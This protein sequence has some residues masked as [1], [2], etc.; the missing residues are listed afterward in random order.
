MIDYK[1]KR[2]KHNK[3]T[4]AIEALEVVFYSGT[5][6]TLSERNIEGDLEDVTRYRRNSILATKIWRPSM[7]LTLEQIRK[8][9]NKKIKERFPN[10]TIIT[11][12]RDTVGAI[13]IGS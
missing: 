7:V 12:Q 11:E 5:M 3:D 1:I 8:A 13:D 9:I 4:G 10:A 2:I 6:G